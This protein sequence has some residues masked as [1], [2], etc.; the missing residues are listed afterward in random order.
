VALPFKDDRRTRAV[1]WI[2]VALLALN[3]VIFLFVQPAG[4]QS[5]DPDATELQSDYWLVAEAEEFGFRWGAVACEITS[6]QPLADAPEQCADDPD[7][8]EFPPEG[9]SVFLALFTAM[10]LHA[11]IWHLAGNMLF[12]WVFGGNVEERLGRANFLALYLAGGIVATLGYV[13]AN[14]TSPIPLIG[15]SGAI[16]VAMGAYLVLFPRARILT[17]IA[18]AAF[19][20]VYVPAWVVLVLF[21]VT[22]FFT[23]TTRWPGRPMPQGWRSACWRRSSCDGCR[24]S[25]GGRQPKRPTRRC[26]PVAASERPR[27]QEASR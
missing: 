7:R 18:T 5:G 8:P 27:T 17:V 2:T 3:V 10:F 23:A 14:A 15:A 11:N 24:P 22:Q 16:A 13:V 4:F 6:G 9:K 20:V 19:Q 26:V 12:L 1:P 21:F 25:S